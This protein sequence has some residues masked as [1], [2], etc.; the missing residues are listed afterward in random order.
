MADRKQTPDIMSEL[1]TGQVNIA[2]KTAKLQTSKTVKSQ[3]GKLVETPAPA[4]PIKATFYLSP[5]II[6]SLER[7]WMERRQKAGPQE[8]GRISKS[9]LVEEAIGLLAES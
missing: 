4:K 7:I 2:S 1:M 5:E 9:L 6:E 3:A 8:R